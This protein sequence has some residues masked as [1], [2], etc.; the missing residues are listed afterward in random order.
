[1]LSHLDGDE[2]YIVPPD[3]DVYVENLGP[4][5]KDIENWI[6]RPK[7]GSLL[8]G[9]DAAEVYD[10]SEHPSEAQ[11][12]LLV[13]EAMSEAKTERLARGLGEAER[14]PPSGDRHRQ[15]DALRPGESGVLLGPA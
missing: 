6:R 10:F 4:S 8:F 2:Y 12:D 11:L 5:S 9:L 7:D 14:P 1:M 13:E 3:A 15:P